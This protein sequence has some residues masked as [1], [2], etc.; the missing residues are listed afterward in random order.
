MKGVHH[1]LDAFAIASRGSSELALVYCGKGVMEAELKSKAFALGLEKKVLFAGPI[2]HFDLPRY[3][4][5][6]DVLAVPST[7]ENL[8]LAPL[9]A[10]SSGKAVV[11]SDTGGLPEV[12]GP[13]TGILVPPGD[14]QALSDALVRVAEDSGLAARF[15]AAGRQAVLERFTLGRCA[16][17]TIAVYRRALGDAA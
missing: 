17:A 16:D 10:M 15:G 11:A 1:L 6:C 3:Y 12:V 8:G 5:I 13:R 14:A 9:E 2:P 4:A 7:Y